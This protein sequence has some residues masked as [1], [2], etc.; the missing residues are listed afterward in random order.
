LSDSFSHE[1]RF[2]SSLAKLGSPDKNTTLAGHR[3][4]D[5][6]HFRRIPENCT[7]VQINQSPTKSTNQPPKKLDYAFEYS[8]SKRR[9]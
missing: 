6:S 9:K 1:K 5:G 4:D 3:A 2:W 8:K 7:A